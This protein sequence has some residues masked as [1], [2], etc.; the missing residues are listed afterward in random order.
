MM[1][2]VSSSLFSTTTTADAVKTGNKQQQQQLLPSIIKGMNLYGLETPS[3]DF[4]CAWKHP[5]SYYIDNLHDLGFNSIRLPFSLE[6][7][8][9][10]NFYKMDEFFN[11]IE[12]YP[13]MT[14]LL[15]MHRIFSSHQGPVPTE[16]WVSI[17]MFV[18]GWVKIASRYKDHPQLVA[19]DIFNE[20]QGTDAN[21]WNGVLHNVVSQLESV[22]P[23]RFV[24]FVGGIR[25]GG[26]I[27]DI[28][29][30]DLPFRD[31]IR[32]TIHKYVFS[33]SGTF[34]QDWDYSFG[35]FK[36]R[37]VV[38]EWGFKNQIWEQLQWADRFIRYLKNQ[39]VVNTYFWTIAHSGDTDGLWYDDCETINWEKLS[40]IKKLWQQDGQNNQEK[41]VSLRGSSTNRHNDKNETMIIN[42]YLDLL[43]TIITS[44]VPSS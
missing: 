19:L 36:D 16:D 22:F 37:V 12:K 13:D 14:V 26:D 25:W 41:D 7:V 4:V 17:D 27:H 30:E 21:Y 8:R 6:W 35:S 40:M 15:D 5:V 18:D 38:G 28:N 24:Y 34:E 2:L 39:G 20:Y 11:A 3:K 43:H 1:M 33:S 44:S 23:N 31:R 32:Y 42:P 9:E 10:G 29:L